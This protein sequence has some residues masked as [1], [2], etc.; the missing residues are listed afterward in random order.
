MGAMGCA[1]ADTC[2]DLCV[3]PTRTAAAIRLRRCSA[4]SAAVRAPPRARRSRESPAFAEVVFSRRQ[5]S[6]QL[7]PG[8]VH[9]GAKPSARKVTFSYAFR[10]LFFENTFSHSFFC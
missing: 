3:E 5:R 4:D 1:A 2:G 7:L 9:P 8:K 6:L 10:T